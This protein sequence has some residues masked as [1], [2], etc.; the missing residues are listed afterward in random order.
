M[1]NIR[2]NIVKTFV[3]TRKN[4][5]NTDSQYPKLGT[6]HRIFSTSSIVAAVRDFNE[7]NRSALAFFLLFNDSQ[8]FLGRPWVG[9]IE[10]FRKSGRYLVNRGKRMRP[11]RKEWRADD[12]I[13]RKLWNSRVQSMAG[14]INKAGNRRGGGRKKSG[15]KGERFQAF[16][17]PRI[18]WLR[19]HQTTLY[20]R[21][22]ATE[23]Q[24]QQQQQKTTWE[25]RRG[26]RSEWNTSWEIRVIDQ[27]AAGGRVSPAINQSRRI[28]PSPSPIPQE[29]HTHTHTHSNSVITR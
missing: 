2:K 21:S 22:T 25:R 15:K 29:P 20:K 10:L 13:Y 14:I 24:Q 19:D 3:V 8:R 17:W 26:F 23:I 7:V 9:P 18:K 12:W 4:S 28:G 16:D 1:N 27:S 6:H 11:R 5:V